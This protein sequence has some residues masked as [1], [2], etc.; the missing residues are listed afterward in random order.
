VEPT[1]SGPLWND[2][3]SRGD[4]AADRYPP[5]DGER[6]VDVAIV[7]AGFTGL[8]TAHH[9]KRHDPSLRIVIL[10]REFAG[11]GASG[12]N[13]GWCS[14]LFPVSDGRVDA[15]HGTGA[16]HAL[17]AELRREVERV[18]AFC[19]ANGVDA[20]LGGELTLARTSAQ[21]ERLRAEVGGDVQWLSPI[22]V[23]ARIRATAVLGGTYDPHCA[24]LHPGDLV[25]AL[26]KAVVAQGVEICER[27]EV[28][29]L[30]PRLVHTISGIVHAQTVV[31]ATEAWT[32][33][34]PEARGA[35]APVYSLVIATEPLPAKVWDE[36]GWAGR[37]TLHDGRNLII[38]AQRTADGRIVFGG[39]GAPY[40][41]GS[42]ISPGY[43]SS[44][45]VFDL[46][47]SALHDLLPPTRGAAI[48]H[49]WGG[50]L[51]VP[52]DFFPSVRFDRATGFAS[53]GGYVGDGVA[54]SALAGRTLAD[55][56]LNRGTDRSALAW[57]DHRSRQWEPEP[58]RWLGINAGRVLAA[59]VDRSERAG[60]HPRR[61]TALLSALTGG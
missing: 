55:L 58:L 57:V 59:S 28:T 40:H 36:I 45:R 29:A 34:F 54:A 26:T 48:T 12:R 14:A 3:S 17:R 35:V 18:V 24:A 15:L 32:Q 43:D 4:T 23:A 47:E 10:E 9:L 21:R 22:E 2:L 37:E 56:I 31:R 20:V 53:A 41:W 33:T 61:R 5:L 60:R 19:A 50:P 16:G 27:T 44:P 30:A 8:W 25:R 49:R 1:L 7:G 6:H 51:G 52:R 38:Y 42:R 13:G 11:F 39:R 46:L